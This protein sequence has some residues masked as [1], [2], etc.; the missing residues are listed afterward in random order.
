MKRVFLTSKTLLDLPHCCRCR[1]LPGTATEFK[2]T[3]QI[4]IQAQMEQIAKEMI[5][6]KQAAPPRS[7][8]TSPSAPPAPAGLLSPLQGS[9]QP[10]SN[11]GSL[12]GSLTGA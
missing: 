11:N 5:E 2:V 6:P 12:F 1:H 4:I 9:S 3:I 7:I 10:L 8:D